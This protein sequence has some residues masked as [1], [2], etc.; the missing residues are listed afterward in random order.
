MSS[1]PKL[2][3]LCDY[4]GCQRPAVGK[5][6]VGRPSPGDDKSGGFETIVRCAEH[7]GNAEKKEAVNQ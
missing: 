6:V 1:D 3:L 2:P 5:Y 4:P 7:A